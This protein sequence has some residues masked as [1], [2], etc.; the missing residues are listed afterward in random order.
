MYQKISCLHLS[1]RVKIDMSLSYRR[2][3]IVVLSYSGQ[4]SRPSTTLSENPKHLELFEME[5]VCWKYYFD[6]YFF[7]IS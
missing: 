7:K 1:T 6:H 3:F 2:E 5:T 4:M